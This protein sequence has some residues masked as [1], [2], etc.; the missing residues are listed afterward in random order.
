MGQKIGLRIIALMAGVILSIGC[1]KNSAESMALAQEQEAKGQ[2]QAAIITLKGAIQ[3]EGGNNTVRFALGRLYNAHFESVSAETELRK[4]LKNGD[5]TD[6]K[7]TLELGRALRARGKHKELLREVSSN[8]KQDQNIRASILALRGASQHVLGYVG[9]AAQSYKNAADLAP[10][11]PDVQLLNAQ[12]VAATD[13]LGGATQIVE[14][15]LVKSPKNYEAWSFKAQLAQAMRRD[16]DALAAYARLIELNSADLHGRFMRSSIYIGQRKLTEAQQDL[17]VLVKAYPADPHVLIQ[18]GILQLA[19]KRPKDAFDS[20]QRALKVAPTT[21]DAKLVAGLANFTLGSVQQADEYLTRY[22][23]ARPNST[24]ARHILAEVLIHSNQPARALET[25]LPLVDDKNTDPIALAL[26][27]DAYLALGDTSSAMKL[28]DQAAVAAPKNSNIKIMRAAANL[29]IGNE[30]GGIEELAATLELTKDASQADEVLILS[31][32]RF[33]KVQD[34]IVAIQKLEQ[35]APH[36]PITQNLKGVVLLAQNKTDAAI[37]AFDAAIAIDPKFYPAAA[38][39]ARLDEMNGHPA[40]AREHYE[41][42]LEA[43]AKNVEAMLAIVNLELAGD[44]RNAA[45]QMLERAVKVAPQAMRPH[46]LLTS[47]YYQLGDKERALSA[48]EVALAANPANPDAI[49]L[50]AEAELSNNQREKA[51]A[52]HAGLLRLNSGAVPD[53]VMRVAE[54]QAQAGFPQQAESTLRAAY[55]KSPDPKLILAI[56]SLLV[57][58]NRF[59]DALT[60]AGEIATANPT[61][62]LAD[63]LQG[64]IYEA[65]GKY[66]LAKNA[67]DTALKKQSVGQFALKRYVAESHI[68][69]EKVAFSEFEGWVNAHPN[70]VFGRAKLGDLWLAKGEF[71]EAASSYEKILNSQQIPLDALTNLALAY[72]GKNDPRALEA[73]QAAFKAAPNSAAV[74]DTLGWVMLMQG[75]AKQGIE[76]LGRAKLIAPTDPKIRYHWAAATAKSGNLAAARKELTALLESEKEFENAKDAKALL[77]TLNK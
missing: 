76:R 11:N 1:T 20:A 31:L 55:K 50:A 6:G 71:D 54:F 39:L 42:V 17:D 67:Y 53:V 23:A 15:L 49:Q 22:L 68:V 40:K 9:D 61:M 25:I 74:N 38:N 21:A 29:S 7:V 36:S 48:A 3:L 33:S 16:D 18:L 8:A 14:H 62:P 2:I 46:V 45:T 77:G 34:A 72:L 43:D 41:K 10:E 30:T 63:I 24:Y 64:E 47:L 57:A 59:N 69:D 26:A 28:Y 37:A 35:R 56:G 44:E 65:S 19:E 73:A 51:V 66:A 27:A 12:L 5:D 4:V 75:D 60:F 52:T 58:Q 32:L 13:N 70:D